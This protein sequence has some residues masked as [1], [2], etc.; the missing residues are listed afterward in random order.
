MSLDRL[1]NKNDDNVSQNTRSK[2]ERR[3]SGTI[4]ERLHE[5]SKVK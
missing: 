1:N 2:M 4:F 5:E 3:G